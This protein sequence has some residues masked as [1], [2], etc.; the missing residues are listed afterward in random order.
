M[1]THKELTN[2]TLLKADGKNYLYD[3]YIVN[4]SYSIYY[5]TY[6]KYWVLTE[7]DQYFNRF[8][9]EE[10]ITESLESLLTYVR[11]FIK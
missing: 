5:D 10:Y 7:Y 1:D 8:G 2:Y 6:E 4:D 3:L 9:V 11:E